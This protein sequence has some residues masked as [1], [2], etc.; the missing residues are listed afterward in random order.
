[1]KKNI[2]S[3]LKIVIF[4][5]IFLLIFTFISYLYKPPC[6]DL[7]N[8]AGFYGEKENAVYIGGSAS[9]VY[10]EPL[11]AYEDYGIASYDFGANTISAEL[12]NFLVKEVMKTQQPKVIILDA[13]AYQYREKDLVPSEVSYRNVLTGTPFSINR[14]MF[15]EKSVRNYLNEGTLSYHFDLIKYHGRDGEFD[16]KNSIE[17]M[18]KQYENP[19]KGF[20]FVPSIDKVEP[21]KY[22][23]DKI[24]KI[25]KE[26]EKLLVDLMEYAK[27]VNV[28]L[29]FVV[30][31]YSEALYQKESFNYIEGVVK[32]YGFDFLDSNEYDKEMNIDYDVD[33]Y[34]NSHMNIFGAD[35]YT[36]FLSKYIKE[37]YNL[38]DRRKDKNYE[39]WNNLLPSW[40]E[41]IDRTKN[42]IIKLM[43]E[44][45]NEL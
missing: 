11:K 7:N 17:M 4:S 26:T 32:K 14:T 41:H 39:E 6:V 36:E 2:I 30:S 23:T 25:D 21:A 16:L 42:E 13:R 28:K 10:Y 34:N 27:K 18:L 12:Y 1:M 19:V 3:I 29:L 38:P 37:K 24:S 8:I 22:N 45:E 33:F 20:Y 15:I 9:F 31:P 43:G 44:K 40:N 5:I 35:K